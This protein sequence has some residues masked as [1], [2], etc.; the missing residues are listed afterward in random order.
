MRQ[1]KRSTTVE[2]VNSKVDE[3]GHVFYGD[4][5]SMRRCKRYTVI[6]IKSQQVDRGMMSEFKRAI[7]PVCFE[8]GFF[9]AK[10]KGQ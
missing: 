4:V 7:T 8:I 3:I 6:R 2:S 5:V 1:K 9:A 10:R